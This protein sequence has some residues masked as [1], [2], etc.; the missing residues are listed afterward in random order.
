MDLYLP[1]YDRQAAYGDRVS[2]TWLQIAV[3]L[4]NPGE[5]LQ[6]AI[7]ALSIVAVGRASGDPHVLAGGISM[8]SKAL[9]DHSRALQD[10]S[11][12]LRDET[13]AA[14]MALSLYELYE[15]TNSVEGWIAHGQ[16]I[17]SLVQLRGSLM[18]QSAFAHQL[19]EDCRYISMIL[20]I[21]RRKSSFWKDFAWLSDPWHGKTKSLLQKLIDSGLMIPI[22][23][24]LIDLLASARDPGETHRLSMEVIN[25]CWA[26]DSNLRTWWENLLDQVPGPHYWTQL[27]A[28]ANPTDNHENG[29]VFPVSFQFPNL[30]IAHTLLTYWSLSII[31]N[32]SLLLTYRAISR[33]PLGRT[34]MDSLPPLGDM[35]NGQGLQLL[36]DNV[37]QSMEYCMRTDH[38]TLGSQW[39][40]FPLRTAIESYRNFSPR[41]AAWCEAVSA[42]LTKQKGLQYSESV[43]SQ[44]WVGL[45]G[46]ATS[47]CQSIG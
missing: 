13:L 30:R 5:A 11:L 46:H 34:I 19:Y 44:E 18:Y 43:S 38:G 39:A 1:T 42:T 6:S 35:Q 22:Y 14:T 12:I 29:K 4:P 32:S 24:E 20:D 15:N 27:S 8:Y 36:T 41:K 16:G 3:D 37:A 33:N 31:V 26:L 10:R 7:S 28:M 23:L 45:P 25:K 9:E 2:L 40:V 47:R 17:S 21:Q